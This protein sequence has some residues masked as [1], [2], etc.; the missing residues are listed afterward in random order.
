MIVHVSGM[1][2][3]FSF[4]FPFLCFLTGLLFVSPL[5]AAERPNV[6]LIV[7]D[8][9]GWRDLSVQ[10]SDFYETPNVD[11]LAARGVRFL[12]GYASCQVCSPSRA[13]IMTGRTPARMD[14]T[15]WFGAKMGTEWKRNTRMLPA[16]YKNR[17][18]PDRVTLAEA[19]REAGYRTF[20]AGKWHLGEKEEDWPE[21]HG[22][23]I[24]KGGHNKGSP[25]GGYFA[26][27]DNPRLENGPDGELLTLRLAKE[28]A[29][30]IEAHAGEPFFATL[31]FYTVH[32]PAQ[33]TRELWSK[34][35]EKAL[36]Q[37]KPEKR[38]TLERRLPTRVVQ[39]NP[40]YGGMVESMDTAV[41]MVLD[42]LE[43]KGLT[44]KTIVIF[45]SDNGGVSSSD[46]WATSNL[47]LRAGKGYQWEGGIR[48]PFIV[49]WPEKLKPGIDLDTP[50]IGT[51]IYP[52]LL[53]LAG[54]PMRPEEHLDGTS[55][56]PALKGQD[57]PQRPL[58]WHYPH[59][60]NQGGDPSSI[61]RFEDWKL[62]HYHETGEDE[63]YRLGED[64]M[65]TV[66]VAA[67]FPGRVQEMRA[68]LNRWLEEVEA[69]FPTENP[70]FDE[71]AFV[72]QRKA[73][74]EELRP[75]READAVRMLEA[76][77]QPNKS[78]WKSENPD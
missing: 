27:W 49:S 10:G 19:F 58:F 43:A 37:P 13:S 78:W 25:P 29:S 72:R 14:T 11:Q 45:T 24:N 47:P 65:E 70:G 2:I 59:Y 8:D 67:Q 4:C 34:Y 5:P 12:Q 71:A 16:I 57:L 18:E 32:G 63:L 76:D 77:W 39:D 53:D 61:I 51:D 62:I 40:V 22:Y 66:N 56:V 54:L 50:V 74:K 15:E 60:S 69:R 68:M 7:V 28:T 52:T 26:P 44:E 41:G 3:K 35:R 36:R 33:T 64:P 1:I 75:Q 21:Y 6:L 38:L 23:E 48:V 55:L 73:V 9:L 46:H 42:T 30:F 31:C 17:L 20:F